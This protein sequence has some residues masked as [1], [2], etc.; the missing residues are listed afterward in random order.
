[1]R[2]SAACTGQRWQRVPG[3][4]RRCR[5]QKSLRT[6]LIWRALR[7]TTACRTH[8]AASAARPCQ[9]R[10]ASSIWAFARAAFASRPV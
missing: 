3:V 9:S 6:V 10:R 5:L 7:V 4:R 8:A 2:L 1:V